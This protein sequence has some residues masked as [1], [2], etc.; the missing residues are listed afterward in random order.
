MVLCF[1]SERRTNVLLTGRRA[2]GNDMD[3]PPGCYGSGQRGGRQCANNCSA[4]TT[5]SAC[6]VRVTRV[7]RSFTLQKTQMTTTIA[8]RK[9][10]FPLYRS[11]TGQQHSALASRKCSKVPKT[12]GFYCY[13]SRPSP[14]GDNLGL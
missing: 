4:R 13:S 7:V 10:V 8:A 12:S 3:P 2:S 9:G 11:K 14:S 1:S 6:V 5:A